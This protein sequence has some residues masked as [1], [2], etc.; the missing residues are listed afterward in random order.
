M[1]GRQAA[2]WPA[3]PLTVAQPKRQGS[4][5]SRR[6]PPRWTLSSPPPTPAAS[7]LWPGQNLSEKE[8]G[9]SFCVVDPPGCSQGPHPPSRPSNNVAALL[10]RT[11]QWDEAAGHRQSC[12]QARTGQRW[13]R[14]LVPGPGGR[15]VAV[16]GME[17]TNQGRPGAS[18][19][20]LTGL[21][22]MALA[23]AVC[24]GELTVCV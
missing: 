9:S 16:S 2:Q 5:T 24:S 1:P 6:F 23:W 11:P 20:S 17:A 10:A 3:R 7:P 21:K 4:P 18:H 15:T 19:S 14:G 8:D 12:G 13:E 22:V